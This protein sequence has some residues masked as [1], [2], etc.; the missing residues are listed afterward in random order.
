MKIQ[1]EYGTPLA[2][3]K[4]SFAF[5]GAP[6]ENFSNPCAGRKQLWLFG[7]QV[8]YSSLP[9]RKRVDVSSFFLPCWLVNQ[10]TSHIF[11]QG[12]G[13]SQPWQPLKALLPSGYNNSVTQLALRKLSGV[14]EGRE[15]QEMSPC[16]GSLKLRDTDI[17]GAFQ[18]VTHRS[19]SLLS[20]A[21][22]PAPGQDVSAPFPVSSPP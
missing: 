22:I 15:E 11:S 21:W 6:W 5:P 7:S 4:P 8:S 14:G 18:A 9:R 3:A 17:S 16:V 1:G 13:V 19:T 12:L 10:F 20:P 2:K